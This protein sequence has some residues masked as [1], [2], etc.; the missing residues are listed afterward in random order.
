MF[1][2]SFKLKSTI[3]NMHFILKNTNK[4]FQY[5]GLITFGA[6][7]SYF[8]IQ[9]T[10]STKALKEKHIL[11]ESKTIIPAIPDELNFSGE[12]VPIDLDDDIKE[13]LDREFVLAMY[14]QS[15]TIM[16]L[17][18]VGRWEKKIKAIL[19]E[20][21]VPEDFFYLMCAESHLATVGSWAGAQGFWQFLKETANFYKMEVNSYVD[22]RNDPIKS[23]YAACKYLKDAYK[24]FGNWTG[25]AASYNMGMGGYTQETIRQKENNYYN[26]YLNQETSRYLFRIIA[27]KYII[28][29]PEK[30]GYKIFSGD[31]YEEPKLKTV[32]V[33][34]SIG[35]LV[36]FA[37][38][39]NTTY[40]LI[41]Y[42]NPWILGYTLPNTYGK[43][44]KILI[45]N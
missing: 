22:E 32:E 7:I 40:K 36:T 1:T 45:P 10:D 44:Y 43:S 29:N 8:F 24:K 14:G 9:K 35:D 34:T 21:E 15:N 25:V 28:Q 33:K 37:K 23:T 11:T 13:R 18:R 4:F 20:Q 6:I 17:K 30:Y 12:K 2:Y 19:K 42:H 38:S 39:Q 3:P 16:I 31:I 27:L 41:K 26:I 5:L